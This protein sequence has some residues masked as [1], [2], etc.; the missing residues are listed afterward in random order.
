MIK[1]LIVEDSP[2]TQQLLTNILD[3]DPEIKVVGVAHNGER[4]ISIISDPDSSI[5]PDVITMDI[6]MPGIGG[7]EATRKIL[8]KK[9]IPIIIVSAHIKNSNRDRTFECLN[10]GAATVMKTPPGPGNKDYNKIAS[11]FIEKI[12]LL[13]EIKIITRNQP[14]IRKKETG[15]VYEDVPMNRIISIVAIGASTGGPV[16]IKEILSVLPKDFPV[17]ILITQHISEGFIRGFTDWLNYNTEL[18]VQVAENNMLLTPGNVYLA[19]DNYHM[20][21]V[22][23]NRIILSSSDPINGLRPSVSYLFESIANDCPQKA[24]G[25]MLSGMGRDGAEELKLMRDRGAITIAQNEESSILF[26]MPNETI[27]LQGA[28]FILPSS[29]IAEKLLGLTSGKSDDG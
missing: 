16:A 19:P 20:G 4:A 24:V 25:I 29:D 17:P 28:Q 15:I 21:L 13:S 27:K 12:K 7:L 3:S 1:V 22:S 8:E 6:V 2:V 14:S 23:G 10:A 11:D 9:P 5:N 26:G 18:T